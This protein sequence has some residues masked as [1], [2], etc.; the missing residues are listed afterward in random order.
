MNDIVAT[1]Q[2]LGIV[3]RNKKSALL[4]E[5]SEILGWLR[6]PGDGARL[7]SNDTLGDAERANAHAHADI[8][9]RSLI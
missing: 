1:M 5:E 2:R 4:N 6:G 7:H 3:E 9:K 8:L